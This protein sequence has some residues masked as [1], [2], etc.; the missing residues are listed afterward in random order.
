[1]KNYVDR[2][3]TI[4]QKAPEGKSNI[5]VGQLKNKEKNKEESK[6][7]FTGRQEEYKATAEDLKLNHQFFVKLAEFMFNN[8]KTLYQ[9]IHSKIYDKMFNGKE[10]ELINTVSFFKIIKQ[11]GFEFT[12][13]EK[14]A[15][16]VLLRTSHFIDVIEVEK[17]SKILEELYIKEDIPAST[18][19][20]NYKHLTAPDIRLM[21]RI[22]EYMENEEIEEIEKFLGNDR[23]TTIEVIGSNK[24]EDVQ[25]IHANDFLELLIEKNL[26]EDELNEGLQMF[27]AIS[28]DDIEE[29][30]LRKIK[31][32]VKDFK[33]VKFFKYFGTKFR[34]EE[35]VF[36][37]AEEAADA[38]AS[39]IQDAFRSN[40]QNRASIIEHKGKRNPK[41]R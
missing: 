2:Q 5:Q 18:K 14:R 34:D 15:V 32:C 31:K 3:K 11:Q 40:L 1:M 12:D 17:I 13:D 21:N 7:S 37:D 26:I 27:L 9:M 39:T 36:S 23:I 30:M 6:L 29:L 20:F 19:N 25:I 41:N 28:M 10:Y 4:D 33:A 16:T 35:M 8:D 24:R 22:V 38:E